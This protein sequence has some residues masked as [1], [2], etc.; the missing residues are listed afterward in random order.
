MNRFFLSLIIIIFALCRVNAQMDQVIVG[1]N[2][3]L[4]SL[5]ELI[6][7]IESG[8]DLRFFYLNKWT[9]SVIVVQNSVP[10]SL[11]KMLDESL[12]GTD[13]TYFTDKKNIIITLRY[14]I[15]SSIP[16][17]LL[18]PGLPD[19]NV[20]HITE[21]NPFLQRE[22]TESVSESKV[23]ESAVLII[24]TPGKTGPYNN[25]TISGV[26]TEKESGQP[27]TGAIVFISDLNLGTVTDQYGYYVM[28]IPPGMHELNL[29]YMGRKDQSFKINLTGNGTLNISM[30]ER[31]LELRGVVIKADK[32]F[33]VRNLQPGLE[34]MDIQTIR[35]V[36]ST[37]GEGDLMKTA[38]LLPG[39]KT[40]GEGASGFNVRGGG[41]DQNLILM[42]GAP[43]F[44]P[45]HIFGFFSIFNPD[46]VKEFKLYKSGIPA[47]YGGRLSSV[48]D[49]SIRN[50]NLKRTSVN[51]G[52]S[53]VAARLSID[54]P[55]I[56]DK[57]SFLVSSRSSY[58]DWI[59]RR[60][61]IPSLIN[62]SASFMDLNGKADFSINEKNQ[63]TAAAYYS[64]DH[65]RLN[66]DTLYSFRN[67]NAV[68]DLKHTF[69]KKLYGIASGI[70]SNYAYSLSSTVRP[71]YAFDLS[72]VISYLEGRTDFTWFLN[73]KHKLN[74]GADIIKYRIN[75]GSLDPVGQTSLILPK[76]L[77]DE[78]ALETGIYLNDEFEI[79]DAL[80]VNYGLR[81]SGLFSLGPSEVYKYLPDAPRSLQ[82]RIDSVYY[83]AN[84]MTG[85]QGGPEFRL[86][87]R[88]SLGPA[89][90]VKFGF[91]NMN[92][93]LY[94]I[95]NTTAISPT[96]FWKIAG[97][98]LPA[99]KSHQV[100]AG[101]YEYLMSGKVLSSIEVY[102]KSTR[103]LPE[104][105][106]GTSLLMN[107]DLEVD[108]LSGRGKAY[109]MELMLRKEYGA[110]NGWVSY[111]YSRSLIKVDSKFL[112]DRINNGNWYPSNYDKPH[113]FTLVS[114][115]RFSRLHS[116]ST[117]I[118]YSTGRPI[119]YP[120]ARYRFRNLELL[121]YSYR[122]EY[123]IP[124]YFR[125]DISLNF[126]GKLNTKK[127]MKNALSISVYNVTG[128]DNAY[129]VYFVSDEIK[130]V[131]GYKLSVFS[132]PVVT[133]T[134]DFGF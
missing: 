125:W 106:G 105:R 61:K 120:V 103:N 8:Y 21:E 23:I 18:N 50:G 114:N 134:Y 73:S 85:Y 48:L 117:T 80:S 75:P 122:N 60:T 20:S 118:T 110:F 62:S 58:S 32:D 74:F 128:R 88:Y 102:Y 76:N 107:P 123:R 33:N 100:S 19:E 119:T 65:F 67:L 38:L 37:M 17:S 1:Q 39:V 49:V 77:S 70:Y 66:S 104:Y 112:A 40:V 97:P 130:K 24:G 82:T 90:S 63:L 98:N 34:K 51:G 29:R 4:R 12:S 78:M 93:Y 46:V 55:L 30:E 87:A 126:E 54:G 47:Q 111:T 27:I 28:T 9:D 84:K 113:D 6:K 41:T 52:I 91:T 79:T 35:Q 36:S 72:Y 69:S 86:T 132:Q 81:Y 131:K 59:L 42:D 99:Q 94:M 44:N 127:L 11:E 14:K 68:I 16:E 108:M 95:S 10:S 89:R 71:F 101:F 43:V 5:G 96:D 121:H 25:A 31:L 7:Y 124:D 116:I 92:Q 2:F 57:A 53:P 15:K 133:V 83:P 13:L 45:S 64:T 56:K 129:S 22:L 3:N 115:Y 26:V 109:G